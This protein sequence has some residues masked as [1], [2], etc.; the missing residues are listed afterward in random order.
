LRRAVTAPLYYQGNEL[1]VGVSIGT[2]S[3]AAVE[4]ATTDVLLA[5]ADANMYLDKTENRLA[6]YGSPASGPPPLR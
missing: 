4:A 6:A 1:S 5:A 2:A 3:A